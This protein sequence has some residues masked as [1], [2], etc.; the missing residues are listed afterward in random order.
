[1]KPLQ[2]KKAA[3]FGKVAVMMGGTAA[4]RE[5]SLNSGNAVYQA[6]KTN[7]V[8]VIAIDGQHLQ[9]IRAAFDVS[10]WN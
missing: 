4:E 2:I 8:D 6:L 3:D 5:I 7:G 9:W 1:M 10:T